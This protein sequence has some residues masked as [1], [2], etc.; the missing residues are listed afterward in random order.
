MMQASPVVVH[1]IVM[2]ILFQHYKQLLELTNLKNKCEFHVKA[3]PEI[4][5]M[6]VGLVLLD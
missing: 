6:L 2:S 1:S 4:Q 3:P 5:R